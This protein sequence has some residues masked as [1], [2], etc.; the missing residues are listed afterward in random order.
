[1]IPPFRAAGVSERSHNIKYL[2]VAAAFVV[3]TGCVANDPP[4]PIYGEVPGFELTAENGQPFNKKLLDGKVWVA[5]LIYTTCPGPCP[6]MS[7]LMRQVQ[8]ASSAM[9][10]VQLVS[11]TVDPE[12]DTPAVL[13]EYAT[14]YHAQPNRWHFL[15]GPREA[16]NHLARDAFKLN[17]V[18]SGLNHST[19]LV[20][21]DSHSRIRGYYGTSEDNPLTQL[22]RDI[23]RVRGE[24]S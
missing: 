6:R 19:R 17:S 1:M 23:K 9:P 20:L 10:D 5:D 16:L 14:R 8:Q 15:T 18:D 2:T 11:F 13:A 4:L 3:F 22:V 24:K 7:S 21:L 12:H